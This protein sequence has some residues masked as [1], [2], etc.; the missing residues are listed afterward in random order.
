MKTI[1]LTE[2]TA[3]RRM[4]SR[5]RSVVSRSRPQSS[6]LMTRRPDW[7]ASLSAC[8][9][10]PSTAVSQRMAENVLQSLHLIAAPKVDEF[11][12]HRSFNTPQHGPDISSD[13]QNSSND[14]RSVL[15][16]VS[17]SK[18]LKGGMATEE[19]ILPSSIQQSP[20]NTRVLSTPHV[21]MVE[22]HPLVKCPRLPSLRPGTEKRDQ[23]NPT[24]SYRRVT[25]DI[26]KTFA[27]EHLTCPRHMLRAL[28]PIVMYR[29]VL[30]VRC[31]SHS[32]PGILRKLAHEECKVILLERDVGI[33]IAYDVI[34]QPSHSGVSRAEGSRL[35][36]KVSLLTLG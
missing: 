6:A 22:A 31:A 1:A 27:S 35:G 30:S 15:H 28:K 32:Q 24:R 25:A 19:I 21:S 9:G 18:E 20:T 13:H 7:R 5:V 12:W 14:V 26:L 8:R 34:L 4:H 23:I 10:S 29:V 33:Q 16:L 36:G 11:P 17:A 2:E 3:P